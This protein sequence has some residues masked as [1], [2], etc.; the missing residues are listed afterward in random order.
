MRPSANETDKTETLRIVGQ[1]ASGLAHDLNQSLGLIAGYSELCLSRLDDGQL[2]RDELRRHLELVH[3][4]AIGSGAMLTRLLRFARTELEPAREQIDMR[5]LLT[6]V[7]ELTAVRWRDAAQAEGRPIYLHVEADEAALI[8]G[9]RASLQHVFTNL[10]FNAIEA[11][12]RGGA[13]T[14]RVCRLSDAVEV[15]VIDSGIGMP[16]EVQ[17]RIFEPFF[18]TSRNGAG[19]G[20]GLAQIWRAV[21]LH[22]GSID[23]TSTAG[24]GT[25]FVLRFPPAGPT[26][27]SAAPAAEAG[28]PTGRPLHLLVVDD[29]PSLARL[30][31]TVLAQD[32]HQVVTV[33]S[34]EEALMHL[35]RERVDVVLSDLGLGVGMNGWALAAQVK[36]QWPATAFVLVTGWGA[37][38]DPQ[39]ARAAGVDAVIAKPY[40]LATLRQALVSIRGS[41]KRQ[42]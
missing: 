9:W 10:I 29:Q 39:A 38:I 13:I 4:A 32:G 18:T 33:Y 15:Q 30:G 41:A 21:E 12:P 27:V 1:L 34:A 35:A 17:E 19:T 2:E 20:L 26:P 5:E 22:G 11:L 40:R 31:A 3:R 37:G 24:A 14:L 23:V 42:R 28:Q 16:P 7:A 36:E 8:L 6:D 25:S